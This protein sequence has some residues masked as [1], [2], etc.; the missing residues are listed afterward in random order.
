M[1]LIFDTAWFA[2]HERGRYQPGETILVLGASG[3]V[4]LAAIQL[5]KALGARV[6]AGAANPKKF[7]LVRDAGADHIIEL[8]RPDLRESLRAQVFAVTDG[9]G[10][11][12]VIDPLGDDIFDAAIRAVAWSGRLVVVGFAAGRI[13]SIRANYLL[14]KNIEISGLQIGDYRKRAPEKTA[15]CFTGLFA[16]YEAGRIRPLPTTTL[17][18]A[19][20]RD[21]LAA[22][23]DRS[24]RGR[25]V[26]LQDR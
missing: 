14:V 16:L 26:L 4:G 13:P 3:G 9:R 10:A 12:I 20:F 19:Q 17:P 2:I 18:I 5:G 1:A 25:M 15:E 22:I 7:D 24:V 8:D 23:R 11:D 6:L 21:A